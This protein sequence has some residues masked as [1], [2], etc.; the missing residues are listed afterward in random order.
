M[1]GAQLLFMSIAVHLSFDAE[2]ACSL[3]SLERDVEGVLA[4]ELERESR[5]DIRIHVAIKEETER[6]WVLSIETSATGEHHTR[7]VTFA[8]CALA[9]RAAVSIVALTLDRLF[10]Q[11]APISRAP[12]RPSTP[13][14][15]A[16]SRAVEE[17]ELAGIARADLEWVAGVLPNPTLAIAFAGGIAGE[18]WR[19]EGSATFYVA[20]ETTLPDRLDVG[21]KVALASAAVRGCWLPGVLDLS[22]CTGVEA[23][24][25]RATPIG[26]L[27]A[28]QTSLPWAAAVVGPTI[29]YPLVTGA[30]LRFRLEAI[31]PVGSRFTFESAQGERALFEPWPVALRLGLGGE[32]LW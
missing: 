22:V 11:A 23:G 19:A 5:P 15:A 28:K 8:S 13:S 1:I 3:V 12:I 25:L 27:E 10:F 32:I 29:S 4:A 21:G 18:A 2:S 14:A 17:R 16:S 9:K 24:L 26:A 6:A 30:A 20:Q 31:A 7:E